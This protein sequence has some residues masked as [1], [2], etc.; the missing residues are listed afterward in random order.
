M[1]N[2]TVENTRK[3]FVEEV[4]KDG[5]EMAAARLGC[6]VTSVLFIMTGKRDPGL[7]IAHAIEEVYKIAT[8]DWLEKPIIKKPR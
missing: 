1:S 5:K 8:E 7:R 4:S 6:S 3:R 2:A